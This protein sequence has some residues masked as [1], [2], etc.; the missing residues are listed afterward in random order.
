[1]SNIQLNRVSAELSE[2]QVNQT[3]AQIQSL[4][5]QMPF[6]IGLNTEERKTLPKIHRQNRYFVQDTVQAIREDASL[7]PSYI[8]LEE[9]NK[10]YALYQK[11]DQIRLTLEQLTQK[12]ADTQ[13]LAGSE[14]FSSALM[15]YKMYQMASQSGIP[16][17]RTVYE[18]LRERFEYQPRADEADEGLGEQ[19]EEPQN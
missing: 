6:L 14:A 12:V 16:G 17:A 18:R 4:S 15:V 13:M 19:T 3:L 11:L 8:N 5:E 2:E 7:L 9:L 10:D 1:M